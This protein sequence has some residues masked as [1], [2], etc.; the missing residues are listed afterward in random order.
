[1]RYIT[2][3][4]DLTGRVEAMRTEGVCCIHT[5]HVS[6]RICGKRVPVNRPN[7]WLCQYHAQLVLRGEGVLDAETGT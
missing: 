2:K 5:T 3:P 7:G 6:E 1:M 4:L